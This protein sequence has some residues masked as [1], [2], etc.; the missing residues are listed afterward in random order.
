MDIQ[1]I[2]TGEILQVEEIQ[3][4]EELRFIVKGLELKAYKNIEDNTIWYDLDLLIELLEIKKTTILEE[5]LQHEVETIYL[6]KH[7]G[8]E[9]EL[10]KKNLISDNGFWTIVCNS[11][12]PNAKKIK[13]DYVEFDFNQKDEKEGFT[14]EETVE[15]LEEC[16][17]APWDVVLM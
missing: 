8:S 6:A 11:K 1:S 12:H 13:T 2:E 16:Y 4:L 5:H 10:E 9:L 14:V 7:L 15:I 17:P 3:S